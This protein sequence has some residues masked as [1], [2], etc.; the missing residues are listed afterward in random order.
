MPHVPGH[1]AGF[2]EFPVGPTALAAQSQPQ[3]NR[4]AG[5][6]SGNLPVTGFADTGELIES[7]TDPAL[8]LI[9]AGTEEA[10][11][12]SRQAT[13]AQI[14]PLRQFA[15]L[16]AF[17]EQNALLGLAGQDAQA[18]AFAN[19]PVSAAQQEA[20]RLEQE[21]LLRRASAQGDLG[22]G[23][24][25]V[26]SQ[27][28]AGQQA[29]NAVLRRLAELEPLSTAAR[30]VRSDISA[31]LEAGGARRAQLLSGQGVQQANIR[32]GATAPQIES[33]LQQA[34]LSGLQRIGQANQVANLAGQF[35]NFLGQNQQQV[36]NLLTT[37]FVP[38]QAPA[39]IAEAVPVG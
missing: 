25:I 5:Q 20:D 16:D 38:N 39:P 28:L 1:F 31:A 13:T 15:G 17:N 37:A 9:D 33:R 7:R 27:Q 19:L 18:Q 6:I 32:L 29:T 3:F 34:N 24:T 22:S 2:N 10:L 12:L 4:V 30:G 26:G 35:N 8:G 21:S 36:G 14:D 11:R 23:S